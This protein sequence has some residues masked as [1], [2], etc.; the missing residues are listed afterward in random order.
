M[1]TD[2]HAVEFTKTRGWEARDRED[3]ELGTYAGLIAWAQRRGTLTTRQA[4][5][6]L[7]QAR[8]R[9][10]E[11]LAAL[12]DARALRTLIYQVLRGTATG[13]SPSTEQL[14]LVN[15]WVQRF[16]SARGLR[17]TASGIEWGWHLDRYRLDHA[18]API[19]WSAADLLA[20]P[21]LTRVRLC[22]ASDC[23][24]LFVDGSRSRSR[25][26]CDMADCGNRAKV[27][28]FRARRRAE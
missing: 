6:F 10:D 20:A 8:E 4:R 26:W 2:W 11:A 27:R 24:W 17:R 1:R 5:E 15:A 16:G 9:P 28:R 13:T 21:E 23:G 3:D 7:D 19:A 25:R 12:D 14:A 22:E 18:L